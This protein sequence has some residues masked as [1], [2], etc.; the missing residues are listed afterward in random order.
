MEDGFD[1]LAGRLRVVE[2]CPDAYDDVRER[3]QFDELAVKVG[4]KRL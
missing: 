2:R 4:G 3:R 1:I